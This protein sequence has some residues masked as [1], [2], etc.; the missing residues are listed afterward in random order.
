M[1]PEKDF[2]DSLSSIVSK[3]IRYICMERIGL[4]SKEK[5][6]EKSLDV[7]INDESLS[8]KNLMTALFLL[9]RLIVKINES[10]DTEVLDKLVE[11]IKESGEKAEEFISLMTIEEIDIV[12]LLQEIIKEDSSEIT[13][14]FL[15]AEMEKRRLEIIDESVKEVGQRVCIAHPL[16]T[17]M[18]V[19]AEGVQMPSSSKK[20]PAVPELMGLEA[21]VV[22]VNC[23]SHKYL[24]GGC[25]KKHNADARIAFSD[26][27]ME[28]Y[29]D[30]N[31]IKPFNESKE[32]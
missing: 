5:L 17:N 29:I 22:A 3:I 11:Q 16:L 8:P 25:D 13:Q 1:K 19:T 6:F 26:Y 7:V 24:C 18:L 27:N 32:K 30:S 23:D 9:P 4:D 12:K 28:F 21:I 2:T 10:I 31:F 20:V 15:S 14:E